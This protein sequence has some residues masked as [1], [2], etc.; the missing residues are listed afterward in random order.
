[1]TLLLVNMACMV[2]S[3]TQPTMAL[4]DPAL[5][6]VFDQVFGADVDVMSPVQLQEVGMVFVCYPF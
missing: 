5:K 3:T 6:K 4:L 2:F 1:M